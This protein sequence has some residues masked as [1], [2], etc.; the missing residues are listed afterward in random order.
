[1]HTLSDNVGLHITVIVLA[2]PHEGA[3]A[4]QRHRHHVV[5]QTVLVADAGGLKLGLVVLGV[6]L[7]KDV[8][9]LAV[10]LLFT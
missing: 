1:M 4:L 10:V 7:G 5:D 6:D 9:E 2:G 3:V 8:L